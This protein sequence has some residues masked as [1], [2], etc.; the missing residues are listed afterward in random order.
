MR[1]KSWKVYLA[2][3][4]TAVMLLSPVTATIS[5]GVL[6]W[7]EQT[8]QAQQEVGY[9]GRQLDGASLDIYQALAA[10]QSELMELR[11][12]KVTFTEPVL[13]EEYDGSIAQRAWDAFVYDHPEIFWIDISGTTNQ[14]VGYGQYFYTMTLRLQDA[15]AGTSSYNRYYRTHPDELKSDQAQMLS[16]A[17][18]VAKQAAELGTRYEQ[19]AY[20]HDWLA[21]NNRYNDTAAADLSRYPLAHQA[22]SALVP[23]REGGPV[24]DGYSKAFQLICDLLDIPC[25][26]ISGT[27]ISGGK[28]GSHMWNAVQME[29]GKWYGVDVTWDDTDSKG[30]RGA[31]DTFLLVGTETVVEGRVTF[32]DGH[33]PVGNFSKGGYEFDYP[34]LS[35]TAYEANTRDTSG[36]KLEASALAGVQKALTQSGCTMV[37]APAEVSLLKRDT[38]MT[39]V[40]V[41]FGSATARPT[42]I[43][44]V[45][46]SSVRPVPASWSWADGR[47]TANV[48]LTEGGILVPVTTSARTFSD[49][50]AD[51]WYTQV[52]NEAV[53][54]L[55]MNGTGS[56]RFSPE[57]ELTG[58]Q[59]RAILLRILGVPE[60]KAAAGAPWYAG[61]EEA[62]ANLG[63]LGAGVDADKVQTRAD[64]AIALTHMLTLL[65]K[66]Q[67]FSPA[68]ADA[69][70]APYKDT[71]D[72]ADDTRYALA[73]LV[74]NG[75]LQGVAEGKLAPEA[76]LTRAQMAALCSRIA[77]LIA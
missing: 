54:R 68:E 32:R 51:A 60:E 49:V 74:K 8:A 27:G 38:L 13:D 39:A 18:A 2:A 33:V 4:L 3:A 73:M 35:K 21:A 56:D 9:Y 55:W 40:R 1:Q 45:D 64:A 11:E 29:D 23:D 70:L 62:A 34:T 41:D 52:V 37:S 24:C 43:V 46:G 48:R 76:E 75:L 58:A 10:H 61:S 44:R 57:G 26:C 5:G 47:L 77:V 69:I 7:E 72:L 20:I 67:T 66:E 15:Q 19:I 12:I 16:Q 17:R 6:A 71:A 31:T 59:L 63:F 42:A 30:G 28:A 14:G 25:V 22:V 50:P 65:E 36:T 53:Q